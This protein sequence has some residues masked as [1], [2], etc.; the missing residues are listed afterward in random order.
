[1][2]VLKFG[3]SS[4]KNAENILKVKEI[5]RT[6]FQKKTRYTVVVSAFGG[7]TDSLIKMS[8]LA[9]K[10]DDAYKG[11]LQGFKTRHL[12]TAKELL[13]IKQFR[14]VEKDLKINHDT[15]DNLLK[16]IYLVREASPRT[17]DYVKSFGERNSAFI[18]ANALKEHKIDA[19]YLDA[20]NII[21]TDKKFGTAN[22][23]FKE[24]QKKVTKYYKENE[25]QVHIVTG[26][27][28]ADAGGLT[29]TL[30][31]GGSD[32]TASILASSLRAKRLEIWT[33]VNGVLTCDPRKVKKA[34]T[35]PTLSYLEAMELSHFGAKVI[36]PPTIQPALQRKIPILIRNTFDPK[37]QGTMIDHRVKSSIAKEITGLSSLSD[38]ALI[39]LQ[40]GGMVGI[41]GIAARLFSSMAEK[42]INI[43]LI[44]QGSSEYA[45]SFAVK[46]SDA[47]N[48]KKAIE[49]AFEPEVKSGLID[50]VLVE[51]D[52]NIIAI[53]SE[54]MR[55]QPGV[56]GKLFTSLG[57]EGINIMAIAQGSSECNISFVVN[58]SDEIKALNLIHDAFFL[59][60]YK[61]INIFM[62]GI[63]VIGGTL[64]D[65]LKSQVNKLKKNLQ[66]NLKVNAISNTKKMV[67]DENGIE[68]SKWEEKLASS[69][70]K[71]NIDQYIKEM[72]EMN[73]PNSIFIDSTASATI[74]DYYSSI[75]ENNIAV[76]TP[77]KVATSSSYR[78]YQKLKAISKKHKAPFLYETN[79]GA[80][81]P[82]IKTI[83]DLVSS[84][85]Q[86]I[87]LEAVLSGSIS[88]I[89]NTFS[90]E[91]KFSEVVLEAKKLGYT[92]PDPRD[93]LSGLDVKR[94]IT[95]LAREAG[96][97]VNMSQ[98]KLKGILN[99][100]C[101]E[102]ESV[103]DFF[104]ELE[105]MDEHFEAM[106]TRAASKNKKLRFIA[107]MTK[108]GEASVALQ[109]VTQ[110]S[111][112]Y[113]LG[114]S[115]NMLVFT[116][117]RYDKR[118]LVIKGPGAGADVT[119][120]GVFAEIISI[121]NSVS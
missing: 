45:I 71:A 53:V 78:N 37:F 109:E 28:A 73:L 41:P 39:R 40:G 38:V 18:I 26:F 106:A 57:R 119:A 74:P 112:F 75:L 60:A 36:Y 92:E 72:I 50:E 69:K 59:S 117:K 65:Q 118:P 11:I 34:F 12:E 94:K 19:A 14:Q 4:V 31:R 62:I 23:N 113:N 99:K 32:Y 56:A 17:M 8:K 115:D 101:L 84:G 93:D 116:T 9:S 114:G 43:I 120:A 79:V 16:G 110:K 46:A 105:K 2:I 30:G 21:V 25:K 82:V 33:D 96:H 80:G 108:S 102:A 1:M 27:I 3:G 86:I 89:F 121:A 91:K 51:T 85:D 49:K 24:T 55:K 10:G 67:I 6:Q 47:K 64:L 7:V 22:V 104:V 88:Y 70:S 48:A 13:S 103:S 95:I 44:T 81:L 90:P 111:P 58:K 77:N 20:R 97:P 54:Q 76:V 63:G 100:A 98:V 68:I 66:I 107:T 42:E 35:V 87:K 52:L 61:D 83:E 15:L 5:L 29:T